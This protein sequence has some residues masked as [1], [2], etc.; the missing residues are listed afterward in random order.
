MRST[1][2]ALV[3][4]GLCVGPSGRLSSPTVF[5]EDHEGEVHA[6]AVGELAGHPVIVSGGA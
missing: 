4:A 1:N 5:L 3:G 2:S 6:V